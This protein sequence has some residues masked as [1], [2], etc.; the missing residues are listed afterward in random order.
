MFGTHDVQATNQA[1]VASPAATEPAN[2]KAGVQRLE[3]TLKKLSEK[4]NE[5]L[6]AI[7]LSSACT[8]GCFS[9]VSSISV[10]SHGGGIAVDEE[11]LEFVIR[12]HD[13]ALDVMGE[14]AL[15]NAALAK[16]VELGLHDK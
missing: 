11:Q 15:V 12:M 3:L 4:S 1:T 13:K 16:G 7:P 9:S 14:D 10:E 6:Q 5:T 2:A 8:S